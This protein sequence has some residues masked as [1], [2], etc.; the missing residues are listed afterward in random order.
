[1]RT[2]RG[3]APPERTA[4][5]VATKRLRG[6]L[7][8]QQLVEGQEPQAIADLHANTAGGDQAESVG[9]DERR[10][11]GA[12]TLSKPIED[13]SAVG[14][15]SGHARREELGASRSSVEREAGSRGLHVPGRRAAP[16]A[17]KHLAAD[18]DERCQGGKRVA[19]QA[20]QY[21][22]A[23]PRQP[24]G[25][26]R[27]HRYP[28]DPELAAEAEH[29]RPH[30]VLETEGHP[31]RGDDQVDFERQGSKSLGQDLGIVAAAQAL[32]VQVR[33]RGEKG[34][35]HRRVGVADQA[36]VRRVGR[37][38][39]E[40]VSGGKHG[41]PERPQARHRNVARCREERDV[42]RVEARAG[43]R[44]KVT[45]SDVL[46]ATADIGARRERWREDPLPGPLALLL[47][48]DPVGAEGHGCPG[49]H[50]E[51]A[52]GRQGSHGIAGADYPGQRGSVRIRN[53]GESKSVDSRLIEGRQRF[54][55]DEVT[56]ER[57]SRAP[58]DR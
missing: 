51:R 35:Q 18:D 50:A 21:S 29:G 49:H 6:V 54:G 1:M 37:P 5:R 9:R 40:F 17:G 24:D 47:H 23:K 52:T 56:R 19:R 3:Q 11:P 45:W 12:S 57:P 53:T 16:Q 7:E 44:Q 30:V 32:D 36:G 28:R 48:R 55:R 33:R 31:A 38:V 58:G 2:G 42:A 46:A 14:A 25:L 27:L 20:Q 15:A 26:A 39:G 10:Q 34:H 41:H 13:G 22:V 8:N 4:R 43:P